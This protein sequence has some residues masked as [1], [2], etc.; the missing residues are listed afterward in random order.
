MAF[1]I[2]NYELRITNYELVLYL[3]DDQRLSHPQDGIPEK[4][5]DS[6]RAIFS[7]VFH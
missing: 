1:L 5:D 2:T 7:Q 3:K 6:E 4:L